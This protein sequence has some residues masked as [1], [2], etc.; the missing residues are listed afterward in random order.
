MPPFLC[1]NFSKK[2]YVGEGAKGGFQVSLKGPK[3][4][5][6]PGAGLTGI[7]EPRGEG[8]GNLNKNVLY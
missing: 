8:A 6:F 2:I 3:I 7:C 1:N 5:K 4:V